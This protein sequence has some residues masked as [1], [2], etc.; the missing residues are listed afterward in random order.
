MACD[1]AFN[2]D[3]TLAKKNI[4]FNITL[5]GGMIYNNTVGLHPMLFATYGIQ[6]FKNYFYGSIERRFGESANEYEVSFKDSLKKSTTYDSFFAGIEYQ[7]IFTEKLK[8][9]FSGIIGV[10]AENIKLDKSV[11]DTDKKLGA[12]CI[13]VGFGYSYYF[14][15]KQ[16][17]SLQVLYHHGKFTGDKH[18]D[19]LTANINPNSIIMRLVYNFARP[20]YKTTKEK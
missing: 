1:A 3:D 19:N 6:S 10:G 4:L 11:F 14:N 9:E 20:F 13:N 2:P 16:G 8:S 18:N 12:F 17:P 7:R 5:G 15:G